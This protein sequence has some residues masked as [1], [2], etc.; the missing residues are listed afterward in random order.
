VSGVIQIEG[1]RKSY[2]RLRGGTTVAVDGLDLEV[3]EGGVFGFLGPNGAGKTTTIR[4]LLGLVAPGAGHISLL[5]SDVP[6]ALPDVIRRVGSIVETPTPFPRF[7]GQRNLEILARI[8][9]IGRKAVDDVLGRVGLG[10]RGDDL[11]KTYSLGMKQRL[12]I[13]AALL[14]DPAVLVLDEP[15]NGLDPAGIVEVRELLR[16]LGAEGRTVFVSSHILSEIQQTADRVAILARGRCV[17]EGAVA[18]VLASKG[19][20]GLIVR[21]RDLD[22]GRAALEDAGVGATVAG[23]TLRLTVAPAEA[24][25][26]SRILAERGLYVTELRREEIDLETV[27]LELTRERGS[28]GELPS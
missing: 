5:G 14:K 4:C 9:G 8:D 21:L 13:A 25:R 23:D 27:F 1:L 18:D 10:D 22:A 6:R 17:R 26:V 7:T 24:E 15:A 12:G 2:R 19:G 16:R 28:E 3:P 20:E 11:V